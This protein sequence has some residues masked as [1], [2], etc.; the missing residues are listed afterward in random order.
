MGQ[1]NAAERETGLM[2]TRA[3]AQRVADALA[4]QQDARKA[5]EMAAYMKTRMPFYGV[6]KPNRA[7]IFRSMVKEFIPRDRSEYEAAVRVLWG[8]KHREDKYAALYFALA[9]RRFITWESVPL[10]EELIRDGQWWDLVDDLAVRL[11]GR[12]YLSERAR[13]EPRMDG[14]I[15]DNDMWIRR[16]AILSQNNHKEE[17]DAPRLFTYCAGRAHEKEFFIRKAIGWS[18]REYSRINPA[19]VRRFVDQQGDKLSGL[20]RR[21]AL[22]HL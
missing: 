4:A 19:S 10:Y 9:F 16:S 6:Q 14:W 21:E 12:A 1:E 15:D 2:D 3:L 20:S 5:A 11:V 17:T 7:P 13:V 22:K 18:L 8:R